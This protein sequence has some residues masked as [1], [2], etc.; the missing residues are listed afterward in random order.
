MDE[1]IGSIQFNQNGDLLLSSSYL[2]FQ[3][4]TGFIGVLPK[5]DISNNS[6]ILLSKLR[7]KK[8]FHSAPSV[9]R[10]T[11]NES[12]LIGN[13]SGDVELLNL[14]ESSEDNFE[15][16]MSKC[17]HD[18]IVTCLDTKFDSNLA[19]SGSDD[20]TIKVWDLNESMSKHTYRAHDFS[21]TSLT[22]KPN[23]TD[24]FISTSQDY[25]S[26][27]WD[28]RKDK[29]ALNFKHNLTGFPSCSAMSTNDLNMI[30]LGSEFGELGVYDVRNLSQNMIRKVHDR[31][32]RQIK[33]NQKNLIATVSED[34]T[35]KVSQVVKPSVLNEMD[36]K[37]IYSC[38][39]GDYVTGIDWDL[40]NDSEFVTCSWDGFVKTHLIDLKMQNGH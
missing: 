16:V 3:S 25:K 27:L 32:I 40:R 5:S 33:I 29:P 1:F 26:L 38:K 22:F 18:G 13:D 4:W 30:V 2:T 15:V 31:L 11:T 24:C 21:I 7:I 28:T 23:E 34:C 8:K 19:L 20:A 35:T 37:T 10:W 14:S 17:Q 6:K 39:H 36:L 9:A 12:I